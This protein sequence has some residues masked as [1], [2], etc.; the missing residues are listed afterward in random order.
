[1]ALPKMLLLPDADGYSATDGNE[2]VATQLDGGGAR[3]RRDKLGATGSVG[4][5]WTM[6]RTQYQYWRAFF[7]TILQKGALPFLCDLVGE[8][9]LGPAEYKCRIIP[10]SVQLPQ[11][12]GLFY[13]QSVQLEVTPR[14]HIAIDDMSIATI[15]EASG[16]ESDIFVNLLARLTNVTMPENIGG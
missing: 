10:G 8:D 12:Q 9:G 14:K 13:Q 16:G 11:Q 1:M 4:V 7:V 5:T 15:F 6:N 3:Y 2:I